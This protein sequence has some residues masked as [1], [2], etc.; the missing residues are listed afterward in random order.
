MFDRDKQTSLISKLRLRPKVESMRVQCHR[1]AQSGTLSRRIEDDGCISVVYGEGGGCILDVQ[2]ETSGIWIPLRGALQVQTINLN[3][4]LHVRETLITGREPRIKAIGHGT[5][6]WL[7]LLGSRRAWQSL[8]A[9]MPRADVGL[10][11]DK[12]QASRGLRRKAIVLARST[13]NAESESTVYAIVDDIA[14][15]QS[16]LY[17]AIAR[18]PGRT[19]ATRLQAFLRLQHVREF[20]R[21]CCDQDIDNEELARMANYSP[22]HFIRV[23]ND[24]FLEPPHRYLVKQRLL[25]AERLLRAGHLAIT[26]VSLAC[27][28]ESRSAFSRSFHEHF[29][30]TANETRQNARNVPCGQFHDTN[31]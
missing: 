26:E 11:P 13:C 9:D 27:G 17:E 1:L 28:F 14:S 6:R 23:F 5:T 22:T 18:C 15:M 24:V 3:Y 4:P 10:L 25:R 31:A 12:Y 21:T 8:L 7:A 30:I 2:G 19:Y 20:I 16:P 29:D